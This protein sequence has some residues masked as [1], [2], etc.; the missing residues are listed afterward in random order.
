[1]EVL[2]SF[3]WK[4]I[5][6]ALVIL[7]SVVGPSSSAE[8]G[9]E[10]LTKCRYPLRVLTNLTNSL[11]FSYAS[12]KEDLDALC[13]DINEGLRCID[14]YTWTC[15]KP[16]QRGHFYRLYSGTSLVIQELCEDT[17]YQMEFL[18]HAA[19]L[20]FVREDQESCGMTYLTKINQ[21]T[22]YP[23][24]TQR[25][26]MDPETSDMVIKNLCCSFRNYLKCSED[27]VLER[28][29]R[30]TAEFTSDFLYRMSSSLLEIHCDKYS[31][32]SAVCEQILRDGNSGTSLVS[33][34]S[35]LLVLYLSSRYLS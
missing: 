11:E 10:M 9:E 22:T 18:K 3:R 35:L 27:V 12:K 1:M 14:N 15:M 8:C 29:G 7:L 23:N 20:K 13:P 34:L 21:I 4:F 33:S 5:S 16:H 26:S 6:F 28:C 32:E 19:C 25:L 30:E 24:G 2:N 31:A 17:A